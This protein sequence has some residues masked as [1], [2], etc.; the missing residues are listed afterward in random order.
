M[1]SYLLIVAAGGYATRAL[2]LTGYGAKMKS[3]INV[4]D[5]G[6][7][8]IEE[9]LR[10]ARDSGIEHG[11]IITSSEEN[12]S[13]FRRYLDPLGE[14][15]AFAAYLKLR[16]KD[17]E[18]Q[19]IADRAMLGR[20]DLVVQT[21]PRG[22]GDAIS[23]AAPHLTDGGFVG[24]VIALGDDVVH[25]STPAARQLMAA[26]ALTESMIVAVQRVSKADASRYGVVL[27][28]AQPLDLGPE[29]LGKAAYRAVDMEEK[30]DEPT[31]NV[32]DGEA[33]YF[34]VVGRYLIRPSDMAFLTGAEGSIDVELDFTALQQRNALAGA[35]VAVELDGTWLSVGTPTDAQKAYLRYAL[36]PGGD[37]E[38]L[39]D[40]ARQLLD[41][42]Q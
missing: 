5:G 27:V 30:P 21:A 24:A 23:L 37:R 33:V 41:A 35:L 14:D 15:P 31:A 8:V 20:V 34:A 29:F 6:V 39:R 11:V 32:I 26:H 2:P 4:G 9:I 25:A 16:R 13:V 28:D 12:V 7:T 36:A 40:Y 10:E 19:M 3:L 1:S 17:V 42:T 18:A 22:F 38:E